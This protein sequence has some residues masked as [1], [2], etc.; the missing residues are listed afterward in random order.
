MPVVGP[1]ATTAGTTRPAVHVAAVTAGTTGVTG[2]HDFAAN[3]TSSSAT[4][5]DTR[6]QAPR[7]AG[8]PTP[9]GAN[10]AVTVTD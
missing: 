10:V 1:A 6:C 3:V 4:V 9:A 5:S 8:Q 7:L 2:V